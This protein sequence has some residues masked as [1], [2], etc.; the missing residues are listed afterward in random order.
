MSKQAA[1]AIS[2]SFHRFAGFDS[3]SLMDVAEWPPLTCD[4][5]G[6]SRTVVFSCR[7]AIIDKD[8]EIV[9]I[10]GQSDQETVQEG[11][12][13]LI[14]RADMCPGLADPPGLGAAVISAINTDSTTTQRAFQRGAM[15]FDKPHDQK[16]LQPE[17]AAAKDLATLTQAQYEEQYGIQPFDG[18]QFRACDYATLVTLIAQATTDKGQEPF[19]KTRYT[20]REPPKER[21][22]DDYLKAIR[23]TDYTPEPSSRS[24]FWQSGKLLGKEGL[25]AR[26]QRQPL[27]SNL[28]CNSIATDKPHESTEPKPR[29]KYNSTH[30]SSAPVI[31]TLM[32]NP[33][34]LRS[35]SVGS[36]GTANQNRDQLVYAAS[37][38]VTP[39]YYVISTPESR[40][41]LV[42]GTLPAGSHVH[43]TG[44]PI[45]GISVI[46]SCLESGHGYSYRG[47]LWPGSSFLDPKMNT[48][49]ATLKTQFHSL[50]NEPNNL[51]VIHS[52]CLSG[53]LR[54]H[55]NSLLAHFDH[56]SLASQ[57]VATV[58]RTIILRSDMP[59]L[60]QYLNVTT[61]KPQFYDWHKNSR[62]DPSA[63]PKTSETKLQ[64][65]QGRKESDTIV[66]KTI[67]TFRGPLAVPPA[68]QWVSEQG[69]TALKVMG[70]V[71]E[72]DQNTEDLNAN[73]Q[74][75]KNMQ[76]LETHKARRASR[77]G[78]TSRSPS[79]L[80]ASTGAAPSHVSRSNRTAARAPQK[81]SQHLEVPNATISAYASQQPNLSIPSRHSDTSQYQIHSLSDSQQ[82]PSPPWDQE[83]YNQNFQPF[84]PD[85]EGLG[86]NMAPYDQ[87]QMSQMPNHQRWPPQPQ[88]TSITHHQADYTSGYECQ[89]TSY[90]PSA[91]SFPMSQQDN[92]LH[93]PLQQHFPSIPYNITPDD[94][95]I[96]TMAHRTAA[97]GP[98]GGTGLREAA[99]SQG[100]YMPVADNQTQYNNQLPL[101][102]EEEYW[103][104]WLR[105]GLNGN[106]QPNR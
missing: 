23:G 37:N 97:M 33:V 89:A 50:V 60:K 6:G 70:L 86:A 32:D 90:Q 71:S 56:P 48:L 41:P 28:I 3:T 19:R 78:P 101:T 79:P 73:N 51:A 4:C 102:V 83:A 93:G 9:E 67:K 95:F 52:V 63:S 29:K 57:D 10:A 59:R 16:S 46:V 40:S 43:G 12:E 105:E 15:Y 14:Y 55:P 8:G 99:H 106:D 35:P 66:Q 49:L 75:P 24:I 58:L 17:L 96:T 68:A 38:S 21:A 91:T 25:S 30:R 20:F 72:C 39:A 5:G 81:S 65:P 85:T 2:P 94:G 11:D 69:S 54:R 13:V 82:R 64:P 103:A 104:N 44:P 47:D 26:V 92:T 42:F 77:S 62:Q 34:D 22:R 61:A 76:K 88:H 1:T 87:L 80:T 74:K 18:I 31:R 98:F 53:S 84:Y 27:A 45:K 100:S 7:R 36:A